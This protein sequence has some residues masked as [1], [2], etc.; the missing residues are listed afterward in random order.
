MIILPRR[1]AALAAAAVLLT[2]CT[3]GAATTAADRVTA[4]SLPAPSA[5]FADRLLAYGFHG[6]SSAELSRLRAAV[7]RPMAAVRVA[8]VAV[9]SGD[10]GYPVVPVQAM[11][12]DPAAYA[13]AAGRPELRAAL[14]GGAVLA[15]TEAGLRHLSVGGSLV[16]DDGRRLPVTAVVDDHVLGGYEMALPPAYLPAGRGD[17]TY[18][19]VD[20]GGRPVSVGA[21]LRHAL[22]DRSLRVETS[23]RN[24]Y[25]GADDTVLT[26]LQVKARFGEFALR[27][28]PGGGFDPDPAWAARWLVEKRVVQLGVVTC[29]RAVLADLTAAMQEVT[30]RGLGATV[31]TADF[32]YEGGCWNPTVVPL[33]G[34]SVSRHAWGIAVDINVDAND[35]G[36]APRQDPR[37]VRIM[38]RHGFMWGADFL[39]PDGMHFEYV[40]KPVS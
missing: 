33:S 23:T 32:Q 28:L 15:R 1:T 36:S 24:G 20:D 13:A 11:T 19:L 5:L 12:T 29:N 38:R 10:P 35:L 34:G 40:G 22:P 18:L 3:A 26:Q 27:P 25:L 21:A 8:E 9:A 39:R 14:A 31:H 30:D 37:L 16:L 6:F 2:G 17:A 4:R 7:G